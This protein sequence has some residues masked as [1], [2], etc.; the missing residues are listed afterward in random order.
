MKLSKPELYPDIRIKKWRIYLD[1]FP[2]LAT[3]AIVIST[4]SSFR[5]YGSFREVVLHIFIKVLAYLGLYCTWSII[6]WSL[7]ADRGTK[8]LNIWQIMA[9]GF[10]GGVVFTLCEEASAWLF[11]ITLQSS[12]LIQL[13]SHAL[14]AAFWLPAGSVISK[15]Y[16]RYLRVKKLLHGE[17]LEQESIKLIRSRVLDEYRESLENQIQESLKVTTRQAANLFESLKD[18]EV[19]NLP[20]Y[21]RTISNEYFRLAA[22]EILKTPGSKSRWSKGIW[23]TILELTDS[24][25]MSILTRP[26]NPLWFSTIVTVTVFPNILQ[27]VD[28]GKGI[29]IFSVIF[30]ITYLTQLTQLRIVEYYRVNTFYTFFT[31]TLIN[32]ALPF[33]VLA[34]LPA[35][36]VE[37]SNL[38][39]FLFTIVSISI[40]GHLAQA[41]LIQKEDFNTQNLVSDLQ[42]IKRDETQATLIFV[43]ITRDWAKHIHGSYTSKLESSALALESAVS[44][45]DYEEIGE[46][47]SEVGQFLREERSNQPSSQKMLIDEI[48]ERCENWRGLIDFEIS[49]N[50]LLDNIVGVSVQQVGNCIE[51]AILNASRHGG[52]NWIG[53]E[54]VNTETVFQIIFKDDGKGFAHHTHGFGSSIFTEATNGQWDIWRDES[55]GLTVLQLNFRKIV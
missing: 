39:S 16:R 6:A 32:G 9:I 38:L 17:L 23:K 51:E 12:I 54:I 7:A 42:N 28:I 25:K 21:L 46:I 24:I 4:I 33:I 53:I 1:L 27:R 19:E 37:K 47:I 34:S 45:G 31:A 11:Q 50:I 2:Y 3:I 43:G 52:C 44:R 26:L 55:R 5:H 49:S 13:I 8:V 18:R 36:H 29:E 41:G 15:N 22:H 14:P 30:V 20:N 48:D 10:L 35:H 40:L